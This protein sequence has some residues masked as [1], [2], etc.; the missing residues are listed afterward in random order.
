LHQTG[1]A[2]TKKDRHAAEGLETETYLIGGFVRDKTL[3]R[4]TKDIDIVCIGDGIELAKNVAKHFDPVPHVD[5]F[6]NLERLIS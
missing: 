2:Y 1:I 6:K 4:P 3:G 5:F